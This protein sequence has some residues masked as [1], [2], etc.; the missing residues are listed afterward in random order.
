MKTTLDLVFTHPFPKAELI[1]RLQPEIDDI[2]NLRLIE[3]GNRDEANTRSR[4]RAVRISIDRV[5]RAVSRF[6]NARYTPGEKAAREYLVATARDLKNAD[7]A[8]KKGQ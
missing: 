3:A 2:V 5:K 1:A 4:L 7:D 6:E 8:F